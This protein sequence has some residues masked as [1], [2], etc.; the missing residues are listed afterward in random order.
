MTTTANKKVLHTYNGSQEWAV[1]NWDMTRMTSIHDTREEAEHAAE[2]SNHLRQV[3][4]IGPNLA[5]Q[6]TRQAK[7]HR[8][9]EIART[10][11]KAQQA[12]RAGQSVKPGMI[13]CSMWGWEQTNVD[14]YEVTRAT[15]KTV[16][17]R[18]IA[19]RQAQQIHAMAQEVVPVPG[20][21]IGAEF[22]RKIQPWGQGK[23]S[24]C[25]NSFATASTWE[26]A[27]VLATSYA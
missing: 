22:R 18:P 4:K 13:L 9:A 27:P 1:I 23:I 8:L 16:W 3:I 10:K 25:L 7:A 21:F 20:E 12:E 15:E 5:A 24:V 19:S 11:Q 26:G 6:L 14:F 17:L 2:E